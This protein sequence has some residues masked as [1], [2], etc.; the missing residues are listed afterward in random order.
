MKRSAVTGWFSGAPSSF[1]FGSN[2]VNAIGSMIAPERMWAPGS[3]PFSS[4]TT[5]TSLPLSAAS[6]LRRIAVARPAGPAPTTTTSY[7]MTRAECPAFPASRCYRS[8]AL[9]GSRRRAAAGTE[10]LVCDHLVGPRREQ[11]HAV[12]CESE[13]KVAIVTGASSGLG[14]RFAKVLAAAGASVV[15]AARRVDRLK[16]LRAEIEAAG[17]AAHV[18]PLDVSHL[19]QIVAAVDDAEDRVGQIDI[20]VNNSGCR[21]PRASST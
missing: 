15:L 16:E 14:A 19:D 21:T 17:F 10:I 1:Q 7:S 2:S 3:E 12:Q 4:T 11:C 5:E 13:G 20:L 8:P 9:C 6:C 18:M